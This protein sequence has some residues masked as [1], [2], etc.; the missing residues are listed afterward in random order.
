MKN[1]VIGT[2][3]SILALAQAEEIKRIIEKENY[4]CEIR[5][6]TTT[7]D[8][9]LDIVSGNGILK[10]M[11][12]KEIEEELLE[13][14]IDIAVHS[15]KD[16][17]SYLPK[18]LKIGAVPLREDCR[19]TIVVRKGLKYEE[20]GAGKVIGTS[21]IRRKAEIETFIKG[22]IV[23]EIRG[24][25]HTRL[26]KLDLGEY[27]ALIL[28]AAGLKRAKLENRVSKY[29]EINEMTSAP[30]Q[31]AIAVEIRENDTYI[32]KLM[33]KIKNIKVEKEVT[34]E[35]NFASYFG[36]GCHSPIGSYC[37]IKNGN[38]TLYGSVLGI[39]GMIKKSITCSEDDIDG[40]AERLK[41]L[42]DNCSY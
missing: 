10:E 38:V 3:G 17:P 37:E 9:R 21:S 2:R 4:I 7:G 16:V 26:A 19:D 30:G 42:F 33:E 6:I 8:M 41:K 32:D 22:C 5:V 40:I 35:R 27:D 31:G 12:V 1:I 11:F 24:N 23:K 29:L 13:G 39:G 25:I 36:G 34:I 28:A 14:K 18:G 15:L 20:I